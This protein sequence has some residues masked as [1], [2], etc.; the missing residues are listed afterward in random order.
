MDISLTSEWGQLNP[1]LL[2]SIFEVDRQ[3]KRV[4]EKGE[5]KG[6]FITVSGPL[7]EINLDV[8]QNWQS[9]FEN[10]AQ[11]NLPTLQQ[12]VQS[13]AASDLAKI[14]DNATGRTN[15]DKLVSSATGKSSITQLN[16]TQ[17]WSGSPPIKISCTIVFRA[18]A[19]PIN[20]VENPVNQLMR[21]ALPKYLEP[22]GLI[23]GVIKNGTDASL[24]PS[25]V[26]AILSFKYKNKTYSPMVIESI[27]IPLSSPID[28]N[29]NFVELSVP[30]TL[31]GLYSI[32]R[33][34]WD[35]YSAK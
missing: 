35:K 9:P 1:A 28:G 26:P 25:T 3:G 4:D 24:L 15:T 20:E 21:W 17:V 23:T 29:G 13:G 27:G 11:S 2:A 5:N 8:T 32:D 31:N 12:M 33:G 14:F 6:P 18:W 22:D 10:I 16:S 19:N 34:N 30:I 7:S